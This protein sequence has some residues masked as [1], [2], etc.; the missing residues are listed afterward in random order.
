VANKE[1]GYCQSMNFIAGF[2]LMVSG[3]LEV[4]SFWVFSGLLATRTQQYPIMDG[5]TDFFI[6]DFPLV[7]KYM[8]VFKIFFSEILPDLY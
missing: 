5:L 4:E 6:D 1:V 8:E 7:F 3:G 2:L